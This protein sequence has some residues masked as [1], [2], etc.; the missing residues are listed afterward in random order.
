[1]YEE[2]G[3]SICMELAFRELSKPNTT[4]A[5]TKPGAKQ[6]GLQT[7]S[8]PTSVDMS[9]EA[10]KLRQCINSCRIVSIGRNVS[11]ST[12][13]NG[14]IRS[15]FGPTRF[16]AYTPLQLPHENNQ[17]NQHRTECIRSYRYFLSLVS[18]PTTPDLSFPQLC[19]QKH[20]SSSAWLEP[21]Y[22][23]TAGTSQGSGPSLQGHE[24]S[25]LLLQGLWSLIQHKR[26]FA[27]TQEVALPR[28][29]RKKTQF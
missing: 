24:G 29:A 13:P 5:T 26:K 20:Y 14:P 19:S 16:I 21:L 15:Y 3:C 9:A 23:V 17:V 8:I 27:V 25:S 2:F 4:T 12:L 22:M 28:Y 7:W 1:M 11:C 6:H 10:I 18:L